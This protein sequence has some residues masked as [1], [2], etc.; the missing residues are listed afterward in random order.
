VLDRWAERPSYSQGN[1][2]AY[3][4]W[5]QR[6]NRN[7]PPDDTIRVFGDD[8][9]WLAGITGTNLVVAFFVSAQDQPVGP[10]PHRRRRRLRQL[11]R[12]R[13]APD[14]DGRVAGAGHRRPVDGPVG[15]FVDRDGRTC[16]GFAAWNGR[17]GYPKGVRSLWTAP[18]S[19]D[20]GIPRLG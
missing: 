19:F 20:D 9:L 13:A 11:L 2:V 6:L 3:W 12:S 8:E 10:A 15:R 5:V 14:P 17:V 7:G 1:L 18:L 4:E 16:L